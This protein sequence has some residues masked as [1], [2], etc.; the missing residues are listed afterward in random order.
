M[1]EVQLPPNAVAYTQVCVTGYL[2]HDGTTHYC[3]TTSGEAPVSTIIGL[4]HLAEHDLIHDA[5]A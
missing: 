4:L 3:I 1:L 2:D 5:H